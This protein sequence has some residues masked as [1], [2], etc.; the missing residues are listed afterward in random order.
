MLHSSSWNEK[1]NLFAKPTKAT[2]KQI[3]KYIFML[4]KNDNHEIHRWLF[5]TWKPLSIWRLWLPEKIQEI[6][7]CV[8]KWHDYS[9]PSGWG[10]PWS[11]RAKP[12]EHQ[13]GR[14]TTCSEE[15]GDA[16][17]VH[18]PRLTATQNLYDNI[19]TTT[20]IKRRQLGRSD[21]TIIKREE[22]WRNMKRQK[23]Q[24]LWAFH[25]QQQSKL[26]TNDNVSSITWGKKEYLWSQPP[27]NMTGEGSTFS[28]DVDA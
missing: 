12:L 23:M 3:Q 22:D 27:E 11:Q 10:T 16:S 7:G 28:D 4:F 9:V 20:Y 26:E 19:R 25:D 6:Y 5:S 8:W 14:R 2:I 21:A 13:K 18:R 15:A 1:K 24:K 17:V